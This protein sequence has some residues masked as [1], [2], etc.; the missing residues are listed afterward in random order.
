MTST[1][2]I[3]P[4]PSAVSLKKE[5]GIGTKLVS[6]EQGPPGATGPSVTQTK[7]ITVELPEANENIAILY[8]V[9][10]ITLRRMNAIV[11]GSGGA[12]LTYTVKFGPDRN[13]A[14]TEVKTGGVSVST[15]A[16]G[17]ATD[18]LDNFIIPANCFVWFETTAKVGVV[19]QFHLTLTY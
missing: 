9:E 13:G 8:T 11:L 16:T 18:T 4:I 10:E 17:T 19:D 14:G 7:G 6:S 2:L 3:T 5:A 15:L 1:V 12:S